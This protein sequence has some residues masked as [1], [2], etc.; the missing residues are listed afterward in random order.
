[1]IQKAIGDALAKELLSGAIRD[2]D[3]VKVDVDPDNA[4][5]AD[6]LWIHAGGSVDSDGDADGATTDSAN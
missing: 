6:N 2:G 1:M 3:V 5:T 4:D